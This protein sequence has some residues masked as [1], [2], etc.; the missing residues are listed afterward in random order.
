[1]AKLV[2]SGAF[3]PV[4]ENLI[5]FVDFLE[6]AFSFFVSRVA[7]GMIFHRQLAISRLQAT[8]I[9]IPPHTQGIVIIFGHDFPQGAGTG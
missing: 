1:M 8:I 7:I 9:G 4:A 2:V 3:F 5:G 6:L